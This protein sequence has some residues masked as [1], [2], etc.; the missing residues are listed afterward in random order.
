MVFDKL[1][2]SLFGILYKLL[3]DWGKNNEK[4]QTSQ[5]KKRAT[6]PSI[7]SL[8]IRIKGPKF[9]LKTDCP[10][11]S[12]IS[13]TMLDETKILEKNIAVKRRWCQHARIGYILMS[14]VKYSL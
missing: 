3:F 12:C 2:G 8:G 9:I 10:I 13:A 4:H 1:A 11:F 14:R 6:Q 5:S 7:V